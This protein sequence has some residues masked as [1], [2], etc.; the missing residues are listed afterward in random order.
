MG[1]SAK[2]QGDWQGRGSEGRAMGGRRGWRGVLAAL[3]LCCG[4]CRQISPSAQLRAP[5]DHEGEQSPRG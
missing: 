2:S 5:T 4:G 1:G 3:L